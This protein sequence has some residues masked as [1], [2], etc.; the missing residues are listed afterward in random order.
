MAI[1]VFLASSRVILLDSLQVLLEIR[2]D[3]RII[4]RRLTDTTP[5]GGFK[6]FDRM[7]QS[8]TLDWSA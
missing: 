6:N 8:S 2:Q 1:R 5:S 4:G 3:I 7:S